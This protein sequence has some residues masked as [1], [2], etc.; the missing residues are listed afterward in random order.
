MHTRPTIGSFSALERSNT[1]AW[2]EDSL[3]LLT[4]SPAQRG[5]VRMGAYKI[6][7]TNDLS[8]CF[9]PPP[10]PSPASGRGSSTAPFNS[11]IRLASIECPL[12][13]PT[14]WARQNMA[15]TNTNPAPYDVLVHYTDS[16]RRMGVILLRR[17]GKEHI[18]VYRSA[19][20]Y[21]G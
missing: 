9:Y 3:R 12:P 7:K 14:P 16:G 21:R 4:P 5:K 19:I 1:V 10:Q 20:P 11:L 13:C 2:N 6:R 8:L 18:P 17:L 15:M